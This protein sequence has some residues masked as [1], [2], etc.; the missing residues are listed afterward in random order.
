MSIFLAGL[1]LCHI[2]TFALSALYPRDNQPL[3]PIHIP[4]TL[5]N[6]QY[7]INVAMSSGPQV[8]NLPFVLSTA[9]G[10]TV[11]AGTSCDSCGTDVYNISASTSAHQIPQSQDISLWS[12]STSGSLITEN[13]SLK[14]GNGAPWNYTNQT[15]VVANQS[16]TI[17]PS[18]GFSGVLGLGSNARDGNFAASLAG[19]WLSQHPTRTNFTYAFALDSPDSTG[20]N[21]GMLHL[22]A[23]DSSAFRGDVTW[24]P[25]SDFN[26]SSANSDWSVNMDGWSFESGDNGK[27]SQNGDLVAVLDPF[28]PTIR[29]PQAQARSIYS[30]LTG[31]T[32]YSNSSD[33]IT[34]EVP[35]DTKMS[36]TFTFGNFSATLDQT[37]LLRKSQGQCIS[38]VEAWTDPDVGEYVLGATFISAIY[39]I[40]TMSGGSS[41]SV[42][43]A[44]RTNSSKMSAGTIVAIVMSTLAF[45]IALVVSIMLVYRWWRKRQSPELSYK[46]DLS[47]HYIPRVTPYFS[48]DLTSEATALMP[49]PPPTPP[50]NHRISTPHSSRPEYRS[51]ASSST[52]GESSQYAYFSDSS[53]HDEANLLGTP[54]PYGGLQY[55]YLHQPVHVVSVSPPTDR[56][57][58]PRE[59]S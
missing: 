12:S 9:T 31:A 41:G 7:V 19:N 42:G 11:V 14:Q 21:G 45:T 13:C 18:S 3:Q 49:I 38:Y 32:I 54:P 5:S 40:F 59:N 46:E 28:F 55:P 17:V 34:W 20:T 24:K 52:A 43:M 33:T 44:S 4:L 47:H 53:T 22:L 26:S 58:V 56:K 37:S 51:H 48:T 8:Q 35:C 57:V 6:Q 36:F 25:M 50:Q 27:I 30:S 39:L 1:V 23:Q 10:Y 2:P 16:Q 15:I 29:F